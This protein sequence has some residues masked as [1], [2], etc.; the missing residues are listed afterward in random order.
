MAVFHRVLAGRLASVAAA[1]RREERGA[2]ASGWCLAAAAAGV[3]LVRRRPRGVVRRA[4]VFVWAAACFRR[5]IALPLPP[6]PS[7]RTHRV[8]ARR[9]TPHRDTHTPQRRHRH[10]PA[11]VLFTRRHARSRFKARSTTTLDAD[12]LALPAHPPSPCW[13]GRARACAIAATSGDHGV[14]CCRLRT[15][16]N[17][18]HYAGRPLHAPRNPRRAPPVTGHA[19]T[20]SWVPP[21]LRPWR[22][23]PSK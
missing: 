23:W 9:R 5:S 2:A 4:P 19:T 20:T 14:L 7:S 3:S 1:G 21:S 16:A 15:S 6:S 8:A 22:A 18:W 17:N 10:T 11:R 12:Q 13:T